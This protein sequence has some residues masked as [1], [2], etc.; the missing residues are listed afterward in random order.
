MGRKKTTAEPQEPTAEL[1]GSLPLPEMA[2]I[3]AIVQNGQTTIVRMDE[4]EPTAEP[5]PDVDSVDWTPFIMGKLLEDE[6]Y[7]GSPT[8]EGLRRVTGLYLGDVVESITRVAQ[9]PSPMNGWQSCVEHHLVIDCKDG[10]LRRYSGAADVYDGNTDKAFLRFSTAV[11]ES[12]A[13]SR[14]YRRALKLRNVVAAEEVAAVPMMDSGVEGFVNSHQLNVINQ[15]ASR[16]DINVLKAM[17]WYK[18]KNGIKENWGAIN[19]IPYQ[20]GI[21]LVQT[22]NEF[23]R[24]PNQVEPELLG[25]DSDWRSGGDKK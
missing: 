5:V 11:C 14:A 12:R 17:K 13:E 24:L 6:V 25:Y 1:L 2:P 18:D 15:I 23:Q 19:R 3:A 10:K 4:P 22:I 16:C 7:E 20:H 8:L 9:A 21:R